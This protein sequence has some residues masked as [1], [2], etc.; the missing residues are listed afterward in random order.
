MDEELRGYKQGKLDLLDSYN[1]FYVQKKAPGWSFVD[2][3]QDG[4]I[5]WAGGQEAAPPRVCWRGQ[6]ER[7][8]VCCKI[9]KTGRKL[10]NNIL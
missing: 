7:Q 2:R 6:E 9:G 8:Q 1:Q 10:C 3:A 5:P 4:V